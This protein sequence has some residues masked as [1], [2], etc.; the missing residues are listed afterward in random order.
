[1]SKIA[2]LDVEKWYFGL[3]LTKYMDLIDHETLV[4]GD[5]YMDQL[6]FGL[7]LIKATRALINLVRMAM[8]IPNHETLGEFGVGNQNERAE[9]LLIL[10]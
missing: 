8:P 1:M 9:A 10:Y 4:H 7:W 3:W 2:A 6:F 5:W